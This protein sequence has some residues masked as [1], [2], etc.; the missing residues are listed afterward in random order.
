MP[1]PTVACLQRARCALY[2]YGYW[3]P[4]PKPN[5]DARVASSATRTAR[6][7][8]ATPARCGA[9]HG[10]RLCA[11]RLPTRWQE[12][13][14]VF[15]CSFFGHKRFFFNLGSS[16][17]AQASQSGCCACGCHSYR[18]GSRSQRRLPPGQSECR[19]SGFEGILSGF[20]VYYVPD[21]R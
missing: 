16:V 11:W 1:P 18:A 5:L 14:L 3:R 15:V 9:A 10:R 4:R 13:T 12:L 7:I 17:R 21:R 6:G 2:Y 20:W 19:V 8:S